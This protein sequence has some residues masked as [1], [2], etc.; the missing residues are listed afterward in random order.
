MGCSTATLTNRGAAGI[1]MFSPSQN[2]ASH[3]RGPC[4][5]RGRRGQ[6]PSCAGPFFG[7]P[8]GIRGTRPRLRP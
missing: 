1:T 8:R 2:R 7:P 3:G 6:N 4:A 5:L